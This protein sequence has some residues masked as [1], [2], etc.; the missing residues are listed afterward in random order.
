MNSSGYNPYANKSGYN[1]YRETSI[2][3]ASQGKLVV[4]LYEEAVKQLESAVLM[5]D[6]SGTIEAKNI[7]SFGQKIQKVED[8]ITEL[9]VTLD[10]EKG[11]EIAKNLMS[12]YVYF[13]KELMS[14]N[15]NHDKKKILF[16]LD[17][18]TQLRDS[19]VQAANSV[20]NTNTAL[21]QDRPSLNI[22]G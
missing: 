8:I 15:I 9:E 10:M 14:A 2:K 19:W 4:M 20:A 7:E 16:V 1:T 22:T 21:P 17:M 6:D 5:I 11:G 13:N 18:L 3:T 12:L